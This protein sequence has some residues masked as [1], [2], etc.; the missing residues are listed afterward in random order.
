MEQIEQI[1]DPRALIQLNSPYIVFYNNVSNLLSEEIDWKTNIKGIKP[2]SHAMLSINPGKFVAQNM[3]I[4]NG[5]SEVPMEK[6]MIPGSQLTFITFVNNNPAFYNAF[7]KSV[8]KRLTAPWWQTQ[9][10]FLGVF[11]QLI[12]QDWLHTPGLRY[13]SV[14][15]IRHMVN[16]CPELPK[17]DQLCINSIRPETNPEVL[18][19]VTLQ[20]DNVFNQFAR[21]TY[22]KE[23]NP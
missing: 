18:Y 22:E 11:G 5:Y 10:D 2:Q 16:A 21:Y 15:V 1:T 4:F 17:A 19:D 7:T 6:Y 20:Y 12:N 9:Y 14:D 23:V 13:C 3:S 8:Q